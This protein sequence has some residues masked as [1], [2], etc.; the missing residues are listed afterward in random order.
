MRTLRLED[1]R[2]PGTGLGTDPPAAPL[3]ELQHR[4]YDRR[5]AEAQHDQRAPRDRCHGP[6]L[7]GPWKRGQRCILP[8]LGFYEWGRTRK[9]LPSHA[10]ACALKP[11]LMQRLANLVSPAVHAAGAPDDPGCDDLHWLDGSTFRNCCDIHDLCYEKYGCTSSTWW[12]VWT[13][14]NCNRC[15]G[16]A[17]WCF[18]GGGTGHGPHII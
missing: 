17:V 15:N 16:D 6:Q 11:T 3:R 8:A 5:A 7:R 12:R 10:S 18:A 14:W 9:V 1:R 13:S 2:R 4:A